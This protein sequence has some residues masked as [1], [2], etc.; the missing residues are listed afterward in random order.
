M[1]P[2][3]PYKNL[4]NLRPNLATSQLGQNPNKLSDPIMNQLHVHWGKR[5]KIPLP[6]LFSGPASSSHPSWLQTARSFETGTSEFFHGTHT[7]GTTCHKAV[8]TAAT[9]RSTCYL[10][11]WREFKELLA[12]KVEKK[13][14]V[15]GT[16]RASASSWRGY[17]LKVLLLSSPSDYFTVPSS[18][19]FSAFPL[20]PQ[21]CWRNWKL[22]AN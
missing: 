14:T 21:K 22:V 20:H 7:L 1:F 19:A 12:W 10:E 18:S 11:S 17:N 3:F 5:E 9:P 6:L 15:S 8:L 4:C 16:R 13:V 2:E